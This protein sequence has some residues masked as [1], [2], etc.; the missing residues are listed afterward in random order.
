MW[1]A[2][3]AGLELWNARDLDEL[4]TRDYTDMSTSTLQRLVDY[5]RR[6]EAGEVIVDQWTL[7]PKGVPT[8][9]RCHC[10]GIPIENGRLALLLDGHRVAG[11]DEAADGLRG[12]EAVHHVPV[13]IFHLDRAGRVRFRNSQAL[14]DFGAIDDALGLLGA[15]TGDEHGSARILDDAMAGEVVAFVTQLESLDG[16]RWFE[17]M[18]RQSLDPLDREA[19]ILFTAFDIDERKREQDRLARARAEAEAAMRARDEFLAI[20]SHELRTPVHTV[21]GY[22]QLV[23]GRPLDSE[24]QTLVDGMLVA[25]E[26]ISAHIAELLDSVQDGA[27]RASTPAAAGRAQRPT[28]RPVPAPVALAAEVQPL[29]ILVVEDNPVNQIMVRAVLEKEGHRVTVVGDGHAAIESVARTRFDLV[30]MDIQMPGLDG[31]EVT[32][33]IRARGVSSERLPIV[34]L[35]ANLT[36]ASRIRYLQAGMNDC[37]GKPFRAPDLRATIARWRPAPKS[38]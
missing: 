4:I 35:T 17:V 14:R 7:Y 25:A 29:D 38:G 6:F 19:G 26:Q 5:L 10:S 24:Q 8:T 16:P 34:A 9:V 2:N 18:L 11:S 30:L 36:P 12:I 3:R 13:A 32:R 37:I 22:T 23:A 27:A 31:V 20:I 21:A 28:P 33:V 1:W 15:E